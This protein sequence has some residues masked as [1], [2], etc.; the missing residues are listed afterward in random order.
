MH[1][2][3]NDLSSGGLH[4]KAVDHL[5][6]ALKHIEKRMGGDESEKSA[7]DALLELDKA[8]EDMIEFNKTK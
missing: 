6:K 4:P 3:I 5:Q 8:R 1:D 2:A 7:R